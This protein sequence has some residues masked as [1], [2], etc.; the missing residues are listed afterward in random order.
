MSFDYGRLRPSKALQDTIVSMIKGNQEF[1]LIDEQKV[2]YE[3]I[4]DCVEKGDGGKGL[5]FGLDSKAHH[6]RPWRPWNWKKR[7]RHTASCN[8]I[9]KRP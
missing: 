7:H 2:A 3:T 5:L 4:L 6:H 8:I 9:A 1:Y